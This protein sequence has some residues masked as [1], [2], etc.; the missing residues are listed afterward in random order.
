MITVA[1][2]VIGAALIAS[3]NVSRRKGRD[4]RSL[5]DISMASGVKITK[6]PIFEENMF[7]DKEAVFN[8]IYTIHAEE[9]MRGTVI[10]TRSTLLP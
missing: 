6:K 9:G 10:V 4:F 2:L 5:A 3:G 1:L 7:F 8:Y